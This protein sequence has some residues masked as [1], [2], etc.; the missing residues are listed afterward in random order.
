MLKVW[1]HSVILERSSALSAVLVLARHKIL[2]SHAPSNLYLIWTDTLTVCAATQL[3]SL[4]CI[5]SDGPSQF[6]IN[7]SWLLKVHFVNVA[8]SRA[9]QETHFAF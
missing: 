2:E 5:R 8:V 7:C 3:F 6:R 4:T 1:N 9:L